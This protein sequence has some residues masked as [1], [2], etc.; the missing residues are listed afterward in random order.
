MQATAGDPVFRYSSSYWEATNVLNPQYNTPRTGVNAKLPAYNTQMLTAVAI[1]TGSSPSSMQC[2]EEAIPG[3]PKTARQ[4][5]SGDYTRTPGM[6]QDQWNRVTGNTNRRSPCGMQRPGFNTRCNDGNWARWGYCDNIP[7]QSCQDNDN[8][9]SDRAIGLGLAGQS[10]TFATVG[11]VGYPGGNTRYGSSMQ[12]WLFGTAAPPTGAPSTS[13]TTTSPTTGEPTSAPT[14]RP[15]NGPTYDM[16]VVVADISTLQSTLNDHVSTLQATLQTTLVRLDVR[17][18]LAA[19]AAGAVS[20]ISL[21][22]PINTVE[23]CTDPSDCGGSID[24]SACGTIIGGVL[25]VTEHCRVMCN[26]CRGGSS[27]PRIMTAEGDVVIEPTPGKALRLGGIPDV[28]YALSVAMARID[29]LE[30]L[31]AAALSV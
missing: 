1:C 15:T 18:Q 6:D 23:I 9:D 8:S 2:Y 11:V 5:F 12:M 13:P 24:Q 25:N 19:V 28:E 30:R 3:A 27:P 14:P 20:N 7:A 29:R 4:L 26:I 22:R 17:P 16:T 31:L 10:G 21:V